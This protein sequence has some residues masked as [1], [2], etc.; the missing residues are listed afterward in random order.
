MR[1]GSEPQL[2][3][4]SQVLATARRDLYKILA[5]GDTPEGGAG[6]RQV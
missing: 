6:T 2:A 3:R 1:T 5:D 4:A